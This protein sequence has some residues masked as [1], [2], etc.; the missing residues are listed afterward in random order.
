LLIVSVIRHCLP[1]IF[2]LDDRN[3]TDSSN[4]FLSKTLR[5]MPY[6]LDPTYL[7][8]LMALTSQIQ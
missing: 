4:R 5:A 7:S 3:R 8:H 1:K 6:C 2:A